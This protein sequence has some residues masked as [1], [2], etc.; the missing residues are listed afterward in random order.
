MDLVGLNWNSSEEKKLRRHL[1]DCS[2]SLMREVSAAEQGDASKILIHSLW[3]LY[4]YGMVME[5]HRLGMH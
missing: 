2:N 4:D 5:M 1:I 3:A